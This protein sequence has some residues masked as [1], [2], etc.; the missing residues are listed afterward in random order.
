MGDGEQGEGSV[1]EAAMAAHTI[2]WTIW[3][4]SLIGMVY[5]SAVPLKRS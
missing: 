4:P 1:Y 3:L 2:I 5:K